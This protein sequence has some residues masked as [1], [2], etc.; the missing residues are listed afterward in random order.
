MS[1][2]GFR[3]GSMPLL[4]LTLFTRIWLFIIW[5]FVRIY[6]YEV[7]LGIGEKTDRIDVGLAL[8]QSLRTLCIPSMMRPSFERITG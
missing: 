4:N 5:Q 3:V 1:R 6:A 2:A 7:G 8:Y